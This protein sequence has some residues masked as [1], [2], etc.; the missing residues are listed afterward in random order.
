MDDDPIMVA[1]MDAVAVLH[2]GRRE[3]ARVQFEAICS[4]FSLRADPLHE[5]TLAHFM[6][7]THDNP[8]VE[9]EWNLRALRAAERA[10]PGGM[11]APD[12]APPIRTFFPSLHLNVADAYLRLGDTVNARV[13]LKAG[14]ERVGDLPHN[15]YGAMI[16]SGLDRLAARLGGFVLG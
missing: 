8:A 3:E 1:I 4:A 14:L 5:C 7:D 15:G 11:P 16:R 9:L 12:W 6:A 10:W 13:H 2:A